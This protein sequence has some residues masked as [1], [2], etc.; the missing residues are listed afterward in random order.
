MIAEPQ[1]KPSQMNQAVVIIGAV[2]GTISILFVCGW[3][4]YCY[5]KRQAER[6]LSSGRESQG[7]TSNQQGT[8][9]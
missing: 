2:V 9:Y 7:Q 4:L 8:S 5:K 1:S 3:L 6:E